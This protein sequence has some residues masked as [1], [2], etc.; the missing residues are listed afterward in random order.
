MGGDPRDKLVS[1]D[2]DLHAVARLIREI[3]DGIAL[4]P[5]NWRAPRE[6]ERRCRDIREDLKW[7]SW[8]LGGILERCHWIA[9][10][11]GDAR[12]EAIAHTVAR[13]ERLRETSQQLKERLERLSVEIHGG[14]RRKTESRARRIRR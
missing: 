5:L 10:L 8:T 1:F 14:T 11:S 6:W 9:G 12:I 7:I 2:A 13:T 4:S 3:I